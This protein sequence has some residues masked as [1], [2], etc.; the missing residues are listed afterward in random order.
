LRQVLQ[1]YN[2]GDQ[3]PPPHDEEQS[4]WDM[5]TFLANRQGR[6]VPVARLTGVGEASG[7]NTA[8]GIFPGEVTGVVWRVQ[9]ANFSNMT[10][11]QGENI[12]LVADALDPGW[13]P[14]FSQVDAVVAYT[15][16]LLS[17]ASIMLREAGIPAVTQCPRTIVLQTGDRIRING[18]TG[19]VEQLS[20]KIEPASS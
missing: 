16:G 6:R 18:R 5:D 17:H 8:I 9:A 13:V 7:A 3:P 15:G 19:S 11:P 20:G 14:Y 4:G 12:I 2:A 1:K 10:P